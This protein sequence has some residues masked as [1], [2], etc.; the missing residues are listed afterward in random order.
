MMNFLDI[1]HLGLK[2]M[3]IDSKQ[4]F[5][6]PQKFT[7]CGAPHIKPTFFLPFELMRSQKNTNF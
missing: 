2:R 3:T 6:P 1:F 4:F 5:A 7:S